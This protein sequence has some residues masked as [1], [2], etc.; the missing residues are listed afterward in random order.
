[1]TDAVDT[2]TQQS[3]TG[4]AALRVA[5][6]PLRDLPKTGGLI[7]QKPRK[8]NPLWYSKGADYGGHRVRV[9]SW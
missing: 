3:V 7:R 1:M 8:T 4:F 6:L 2:E 5:N 9:C